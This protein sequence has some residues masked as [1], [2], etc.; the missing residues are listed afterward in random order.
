MCKSGGIAAALQV[1]RCST[2]SRLNNDRQISYAI[3]ASELWL[4]A[5]AAPAVAK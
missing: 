5:G 4:F 1:E 2:F 3:I